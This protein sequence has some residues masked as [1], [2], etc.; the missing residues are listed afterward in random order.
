MESGSGSRTAVMSPKFEWRVLQVSYYSPILFRSYSLCLIMLPLPAKCV[1]VIS[2]LWFD[3]KLLIYGNI[4]QYLGPST[5]ELLQ[6]IL[7]TQTQ[8]NSKLSLYKNLVAATCARLEGIEITVRILEPTM[9][10]Q[11]KKID[12][13]NDRARRNNVIVYKVPEILNET[14][15]VIG[16]ALVKGIFS[17]RLGVEGTS[18][19]RIHRLCKTKGTEIDLSIWSFINTRKKKQ[20]LR[21]VRNCKEQT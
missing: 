11:E 4:G 12:E 20:F 21:T 19:K 5:E 17:D 7:E 3:L 6:L 15:G 14:K 8:I 16:N 9:K 18:I 1:D 10:Q 2:L 13:L